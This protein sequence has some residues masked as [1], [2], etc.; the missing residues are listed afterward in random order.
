MRDNGDGDKYE[1]L[2]F[3]TSE[4]KG[5]CA[6]LLKTRLELLPQLV[7]VVRGDISIA[8]ALD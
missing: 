8:D 6:F 3:R 5:L 1:A 2:R 7:N 4:G